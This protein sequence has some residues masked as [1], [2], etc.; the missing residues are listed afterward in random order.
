MIDYFC[1]RVGPELWAEPINVLTNLAFFISA[2]AVWQLA[3]RLHKLSPGIWILVILI[4]FIGIGSS[5]FH[6]FA[7]TWAY[8]LDLVPILLFQLVYLWQYAYRIIK[9]NSKSTAGLLVLSSVAAYVCIQ[10]PWILNNSLMYA[11]TFLGLIGLGSYH[12]LHEKKERSIFLFSLGVLIL[13]LSLHIVDNT[14]CPY[15]PIGTH[16]FWHLFAALLTYMVARAL[17]I[18]LV[19]K[20]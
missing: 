11:P 18:N 19:T 12:Y 3:F 5:L 20:K 16:F 9:L 10:F 4:V 6:T 14:I 7:T 17:L 13:S 1:E 2:W 8:L 15:F